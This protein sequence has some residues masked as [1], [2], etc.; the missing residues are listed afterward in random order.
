MGQLAMAEENNVSLMLM[1]GKSIL[2]LNKIE[3]LDSIFEQIK[4]IS[5][6][7]LQDIANEMF[8]E[9]DLSFLTYLPKN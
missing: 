1:M 7:D 5:S 8:Q 9:S 6:A 2:D 3:S 4:K